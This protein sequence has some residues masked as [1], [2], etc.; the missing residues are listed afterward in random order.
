MRKSIRGGMGLG[1]ALYVQSVVRHLV[2]QGQSLR[3]CTAWPDVFKQL[4]DR[5]TTAPFSR[6]VQILAHYS[7]R[8]QKPGTTQFEDVCITAGLREKVDL[9]LDWKAED[10]ALVAWLKDS[11]DG[12]PIVL[13]QLPRSPMGRTD[14]FGAELLPDCRVIDRAIARLKERKRAL[15]VQVGKGASLYG[16]HGIDI[17]LANKTTVRQMLDLSTI[18]SGFLGYVSFLVPLAESFSKPALLVWSSRG[19]KSRQPYISAITPKKVLHKPSS[20]FVLD[21]AKPAQIHEAA[22]AFMQ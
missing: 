15:I 13:V 12:R 1:D 11:A 20:R 4:G 10:A 7:A 16:L 18:A 17:D 22:D 5:V 2:E 3:V 19:L 21:D 14:G 6:Q 8:K 9:R